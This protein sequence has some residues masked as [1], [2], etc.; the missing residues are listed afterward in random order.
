ML[1]SKAVLNL[2]FNDLRTS[3]VL[4]LWEPF[5]ESLGLRSIAVSAS[6]ELTPYSSENDAFPTYCFFPMFVAL[7]QY[8][9]RVITP[10][11]MTITATF[12]SSPTLFL[13]IF[14]DWWASRGSDYYSFHLPHRQR[15]SRLFQRTVAGASLPGG[16]LLQSP[17][18][19]ALL[20]PLSALSAT[21]IWSLVVSMCL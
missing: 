13:Q 11:I 5:H 6:F 10:C 14:P 17:K 1:N 7:C 21:G 2:S 4:E 18:N 19:E 8:I 9:V 16:V 20:A 3:R 12:S 15:G